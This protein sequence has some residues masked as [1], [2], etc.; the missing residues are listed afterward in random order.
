MFFEDD[1]E[2]TDSLKNYWGNMLGPEPADR[3]VLE[4]D[5]WYCLEHMIRAN[6][7]GKALRLSDNPFMFKD[8]TVTTK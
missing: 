4:R 7:P 8:V 3:I 1:F 2:S 5:R 6:D